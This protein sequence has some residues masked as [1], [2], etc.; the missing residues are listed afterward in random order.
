MKPYDMSVVVR[1]Q[2]IAEQ[3]APDQG[4]YAWAYTITIRNTGR[5]AAQL[6]SRH[7]V[8]TDAVDRIQEVRGLGVVGHQPLLQP[9]EVFE[10]TSGTTLPTPTGMMHGEFFCTADDGQQFEVPIPPF[11]LAAPN[12]LH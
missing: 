6:V 7:W 2:F 4:V 1:T 9:G 12:T 5:V 11:S 10:Y 3:S 8:I